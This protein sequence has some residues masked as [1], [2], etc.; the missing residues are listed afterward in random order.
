MRIS[1]ICVRLVGA[2][3][4]WTARKWRIG[5]LSK[6]IVF[7]WKL[8]GRCCMICCSCSLVEIEPLGRRKLRSPAWSDVFIYVLIYMCLYV[9]INNRFSIK[10]FVNVP[11]C[12]WNKGGG[13]TTS[14]VPRPVPAAFALLPK[15][16]NKRNVGTAAGA[17]PPPR[18]GRAGPGR[19]GQ[20]SP[21]VA[22]GQEEKR[23]LG[24]LR[25]ISFLIRLLLRCCGC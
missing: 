20:R 1:R 7:L 8:G 17:D 9:Y 19:A 16:S 12:L 15:S 22:A 14:S 11:T 4:L 23:H 18:L 24:K 13:F 3:H 21:R 25:V 10:R 6:K 5:L 2:V